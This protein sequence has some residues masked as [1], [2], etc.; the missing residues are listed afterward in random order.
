MRFE[1]KEETA[2]ASKDGESPKVA[3]TAP[4]WLFVSPDADFSVI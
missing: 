2:T 1:R 3:K 4:G